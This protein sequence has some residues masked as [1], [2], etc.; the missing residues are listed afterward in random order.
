MATVFDVAKYIAEKCG[1]ID[2]WKLQK[3]VYYSQA[4]SLVWDEAPLFDSKIQ[5]WANGPVCPDL[6]ASHRGMYAVDAS[7]PIWDGADIE[8]LTEN[9]R[10]TI[11][12]V[13]RDYGNMPGYELRELTHLEDPWI[14]ARGDALPM[15]PCSDE[16]TPSSMRLYYG[17]L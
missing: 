13:I 17:A 15:E 12:A 3:L 10:D 6:F 2:T 8:T 4:W 9:E 1:K 7:S 5:A 16:I 14:K 11:D